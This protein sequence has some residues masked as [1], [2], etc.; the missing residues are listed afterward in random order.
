MAGI[1]S[2]AA[3]FFTA[4]V[5]LIVTTAVASCASDRTVDGESDVL[6][7]ITAPMTADR[8]VGGESYVPAPILADQAETGS[9]TT[10]ASAVETPLPRRNMAARVLRNVNI[11]AADPI[12]IRIPLIKVEAPIVGLGLRDNGTIEIPTDTDETGWWRGGPE[13]GEP[14][15]AVILGHIDSYVGPAV[16]Y[17]LQ[18]LKAGDE[19]HIDRQDGTTVTYIVESSQLYAK[20]VFPTEAVYGTTEQ[21]TLRL[22]TCGGDFDDSSRSYE[23]NFVVFASIA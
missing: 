4:V 5:A 1:K 2:L 7:P 14:G 23:G 13:P 21:S 10:T 20:D 18:E 8:T 22:I 12:S 3:A 11:Q 9:P 6:A 17:R 15:P 16:F 19:V